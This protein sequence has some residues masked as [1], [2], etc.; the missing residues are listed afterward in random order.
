MTSPRSF[1]RRLPTLSQRARRLA[2]IGAFTG[3]PVLQ[4]GYWAVVVPG[5]LST[6]IWAP[7][8]L[9]LFGIT[10]VSVLALYGYGQRRM[11]YGMRQLDERER[12]MHDR[13][14]VLSYGVVTTVVVLALG[15]LAGWAMNEPVVIEMASLVP[16]L[17]AA[18]LYLP[19]LPFAALAW[20]E[21]DAPSGDE[22]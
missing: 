15:G 7:V 17:I 10:I 5:A 12:A 6:A 14:L 19:T 9:V 2:V 13:A 11:G 21:P 20:I 16:V 1:Y 8:A 3:Y 4:L 18:G 22:A